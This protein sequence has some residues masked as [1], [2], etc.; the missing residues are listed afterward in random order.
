VAD[1]GDRAFASIVSDALR[2]G[3]AGAGT[4]LTHSFAVMGTRANMVLVGGT[5]G[6]C[7]ELEALT[8]ELERLWTRFSSDSDIQRLN[9]A[10]GEATAVSPLTVTLVM[11]ML[12]ATKLTAGEYD[13]TILPRL[14][15]E[16][17]HAS[18]V[19][20]TRVT[21]LPSSAVWPID[22]STTTISGT[23]ITLPRGATLDPGGVGKGLAADILAARALELGALG[24]LIEIGGDVRIVGTPPD[25]ERWRIG[26]E[27]PFVED[28]HAAVVNLVDGAVATSSVL[29]RTW[30]KDNRARHH[31]I[32][33]STGEPMKSDVV[34]VSVIA[35]SASIAE[36]VATCGFIRADFVS[37]APTLGTAALLIFRDGS[38]TETANWK[39]YS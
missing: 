2:A 9:M 8:R 21:Q 33:P 39:D 12:A 23:T 29:K 7:L 32:D 24:A 10:E 38:R 28:E 36:V 27:N 15:A 25:N 31:L 35:V 18:R 1:H 4:V 37:W 14:L 34:S 19:D 17:Y 22:I 5:D 3:Y 26:I 11:E 6:M 30:T 16:G 13:P 20:A